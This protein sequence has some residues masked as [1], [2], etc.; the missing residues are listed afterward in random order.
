MITISDF[1]KIV[2]GESHGRFSQPASSLKTKKKKEHENEKN[3]KILCVA[4]ILSALFTL[5]ALPSSA[6]T[7]VASKEYT[8]G[9]DL[10]EF[11]HNDP[12]DNGYGRIRSHFNRFLIN[13]TGV[14]T[15]HNSY[16][17]FGMV[18]FGD[19]TNSTNWAEPGE[20]TDRYDVRVDSFGT[21]TY[22]MMR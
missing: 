11:I 4:F 10:D 7:T 12:I 19:R 13:E 16:R 3:K 6:F 22:S 5:L 9:G 17:Q 2:G 14:D 15:M 1:E 8:V 18:S 21:A 20:W